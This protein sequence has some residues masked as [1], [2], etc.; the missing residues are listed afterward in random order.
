MRVK[1]RLAIG[2]RTIGCVLYV[3]QD[4]IRSPMF[5]LTSLPAWSGTA[6]RLEGDLKTI[7]F[8]GGVVT[9][10]YNQGNLS[11]LGSC[12]CDS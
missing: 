9:P 10:H 2:V 8:H 5:K 6:T 4:S 1:Y 3:E 7:L 12:R 11:N